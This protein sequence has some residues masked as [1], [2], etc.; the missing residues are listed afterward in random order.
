[1]DFGT[2]VHTDEVREVDARGLAGE[3][4]AIRTGRRG[5]RPLPGTRDAAYGLPESGGG[6]ED[7]GVRSVELVE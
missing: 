7:F 3:L 6:G 4:T 5:L 2:S 1:M